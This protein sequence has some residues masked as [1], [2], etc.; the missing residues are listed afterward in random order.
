MV[1]VSDLFLTGALIATL[2]LVFILGAVLVWITDR[3]HRLENRYSEIFTLMHNHYTDLNLHP[4]KH[5]WL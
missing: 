4:K 3:V 2:V 1:M 5:N